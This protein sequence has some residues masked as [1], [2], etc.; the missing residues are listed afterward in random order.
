MDPSTRSDQYCILQ[1]L[2]DDNTKRTKSSNKKSKKISGP[3][4]YLFSRC[5]KTGTNGR[6]KLVGPMEDEFAED[7]FCKFFKLKSG[8]EP[9]MDPSGSLGFPTS[10]PTSD[11]TKSIAQKRKKEKLE[12]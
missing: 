9:S 3:S 5:G 2:V 10:S 11:F 1:V 4:Y 7:E 12:C 8:K 6:S